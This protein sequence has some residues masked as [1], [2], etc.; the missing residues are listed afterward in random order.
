MTEIREGTCP[1]CGE[2][3]QT[4][5]ES[6]VYC[7]KRCADKSRNVPAIPV[8]YQGEVRLQDFNRF[9]EDIK[10]RVLLGETGLKI[11]AFDLECTSLK[12]NIGRI[13]CASFLSLG[14]EPYTFSGID[15]PYKKADVYDDSRLALAIRDELEKFDIIIGHNGKMFDTKFLNTRL[16]RVGLRTKKAQVQIDTM[17]SWRSKS[18]GWSGLDAIQKFMLPD[19]AHKTDIQWEMWMRALGWSKTLRDEAMASITEHCENDVR[20]LMEVYLRLV[21]MNVIRSIKKD[22]G[23]L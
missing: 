9:P 15:R 18:S 5:N 19:G 20:V 13:L 1:I 2:G 23:V 22:G 10:R 21:D 3:F 16:M 14:G 11:V 12:P 17:W 6:K 4:T 8:G 7:T